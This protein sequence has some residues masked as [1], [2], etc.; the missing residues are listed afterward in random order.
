MRQKGDHG[1]DD[2]LEVGTAI[3]TPPKLPETDE[4]IVGFIRAEKGKFCGKERIFL[5]FKIV[6]PNEHAETELYLCCPVPDNKKFGIGSKFVDAWRVAAG[7]WPLRRDRLSTKIFRGKYFQASIRTVKHSQH[8][9]KRP[10]CQWYSKVDR[11]I[12]VV[13]G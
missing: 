13:A 8:G 6:Q 1:D 12:E 5:W 7:R 9:V 4:Y 2:D 3:G 10:E 11:L